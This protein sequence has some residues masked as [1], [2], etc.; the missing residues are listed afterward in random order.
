[1]CEKLEKKESNL[2]HTR[3]NTE[4]RGALCQSQRFVD[5]SGLFLKMKQKKKKSKFK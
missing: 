1:M 2:R 3:G 5:D 4:Q